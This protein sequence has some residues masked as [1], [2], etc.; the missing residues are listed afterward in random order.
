M[1]KQ[2]VGYIVFTDALADYLC[3]DTS[4]TVT[5]Y[6]INFVH[7]IFYMFTKYLKEYASS[8]ELNHVP[9]SCHSYVK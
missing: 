3:M 9:V 1:K 2:T 8:E 6:Q 4:G 7:I 5:G